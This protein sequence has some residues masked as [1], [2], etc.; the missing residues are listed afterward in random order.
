MNSGQNGIGTGLVDDSNIG[1][2]FS[3]QV[4]IYYFNLNEEL[5]KAGFEPNLNN[6]SLD[7]FNNNQFDAFYLSNLSNSNAANLINNYAF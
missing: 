6:S 2:A 3:H 4:G 5:G 1:Q 7:P